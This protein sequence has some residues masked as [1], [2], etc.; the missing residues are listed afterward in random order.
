MARI[1]FLDQVPIGVFA[2]PATVAST[3]GSFTGS[4]T[5]SLFG[6]ASYAIN[7][8]TASYALNAGDPFPYTGSAIITGSLFVIGSVTVSGSNTF[9]NIGPAVFSGSVTGLQGF[10]GSLFGT[11]SWAEY[12]ITASYA[13]SSQADGFRIT[14]ASYTASVG[15]NNI[16]LIN[17]AS[18]NILTINNSQSVIISSSANNVLQLNNSNN[19]T[20]LNVSQSG[21][22]TLSTQS[23]ELTGSAPNGGIYFTSAS[24]YVGLS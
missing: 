7:A 6:T 4:F 11:A 19:T 10:T 17:S 15:V 22:L 16:F 9:T 21:I 20:I 3:S 14:S 12:A 1:R 5:G 18:A 23:V 2:T 24:F 8:L 13:L